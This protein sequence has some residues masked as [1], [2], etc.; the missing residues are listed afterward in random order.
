M[1]DLRELEI[2]LAPFCGPSVF[3]SFTAQLGSAK[4]ALALL[5]RV[6]FFQKSLAQAISYR[7]TPPRKVSKQFAL[8]HFHPKFGS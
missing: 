5:L 8:P 7:H 4:I 1:A 2:A 6:I 3:L